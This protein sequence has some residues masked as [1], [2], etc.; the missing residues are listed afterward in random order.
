MPLFARCYRLLLTL[1]VCWALAAC[2]TMPDVLVTTGTG[3]I[4][5]QAE[6]LVAQVYAGTDQPLPYGG[7]DIDNSLALL[8]SRW[9]SLKVLFEEGTLGLTEEGDV[10]VRT[11]GDRGRAAQKELRRLVRA[12]NNDRHVLYRAMTDAGGFDGDLA[13]RMIDYTEDV[14]A[15]QWAT[16]APKG[17]WIQDSRGQ[18]FRKQ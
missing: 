2:E 11:Y 12:E 15:E 18:W 9:P 1:A 4:K 5:I 10:A 8:K 14:F 7:P 17:W 6:R 13:V 16:Q 3:G